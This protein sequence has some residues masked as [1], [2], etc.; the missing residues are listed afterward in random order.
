M[1]RYGA[2]ATANTN[3]SNMHRRTSSHSVPP[4]EGLHGGPELAH[5]QRSVSGGQNIDPDVFPPVRSRA[6]DP[7]IFLP[8]IPEDIAF[9]DEYEEY[10]HDL[11]LSDDHPGLSGSPSS[12][13][14]SAW[15]R[16]S[17]FTPAD[18]GTDTISDSESIVSIGELGPEQRSEDAALAGHDENVNDW[19]VIEL[20]VKFHYIR[21]NNSCFIAYESENHGGS[22]QVT[23]WDTSLK[24]RVWVTACIT[25][26]VGR[27]KCCG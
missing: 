6:R 17:M 9:E 24:F 18:I 11:G 7:A 1:K 13:G 14:L 5:L 2:A 12:Q 8:Y 26:W 10:L 27:W 19:E 16:L 3:Q 15:Q 4:L 23:C 25:V 20:S 22:S 21:L